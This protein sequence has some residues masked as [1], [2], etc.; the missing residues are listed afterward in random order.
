MP[1]VSV[2]EGE[3]VLFEDLR[4]SGTST[5]P[6]SPHGIVLLDECLDSKRAQQKQGVLLRMT[7]S[8]KQMICLQD[9]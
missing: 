3:V 8:P 4:A 2:Y 5:Y 1:E 7:V 6:S 9:S